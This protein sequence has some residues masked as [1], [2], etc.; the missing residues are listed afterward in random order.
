MKM[1]RRIS[2]STLLAFTAALLSIASSLPISLKS[3]KVSLK[4]DKVS[5]KPDNNPCLVC[6][7]LHIRTCHPAPAAA[8][9][10]TFNSRIPRVASASSS[11]TPILS[12]WPGKLQSLHLVSGD[13]AEPVSSECADEPGCGE[14]GTRTICKI[15]LKAK[16]ESVYPPL[17]PSC[18]VVTV[19]SEGRKVRTLRCT[20]V[21]K[22]GKEMRRKCRKVPVK[23]C[24]QVACSRC[25]TSGTER[26]EC[27][28]KPRKVCQ[29][30]E[31]AAC[32]ASQD[33]P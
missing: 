22:R 8:V 23:V 19:L 20:M 10:Q 21:Q 15:R 32:R 28:Y 12:L 11:K 27:S 4:S 2:S 25:Y 9:P 29:R 31:G 3:D 7:T 18:K 30:S 16:C 5:L 17:S 1:S 26:W 24:G 13:Q 6:H 33:L 14:G